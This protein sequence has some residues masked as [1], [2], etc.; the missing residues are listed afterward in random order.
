[1][2]GAH[3]FPP[4]G[5]CLGRAGQSERGWTLSP[6]QKQPDS[7]RVPSGFLVPSGSASGFYDH[8][9][10]N[11]SAEDRR[12]VD[13][14]G[15]GQCGRGTRLDPLDSSLSLSVIP[16]SGRTVIVIETNLPEPSASPGSLSTVPDVVDTP[17]EPTCA[18]WPGVQLTSYV[19]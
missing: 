16:L 4:A 15:Y 14:D 10:D 5:I 1:M 13:D 8:D 18:R 6:T 19:F 11:E 3:T 7:K 12:T 2:L 9:H 17:T